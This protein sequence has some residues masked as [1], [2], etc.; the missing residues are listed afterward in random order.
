M[1]IKESALP[2]FKLMKEVGIFH[3]NPRSAAEHISEVWDNIELWWQSDQV[4]QV[5]KKFCKKYSCESHDLSFHL[6]EALRIDSM[7]TH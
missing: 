1:E 7:K 4:Q 2:Y 5:R 3:E 6:K